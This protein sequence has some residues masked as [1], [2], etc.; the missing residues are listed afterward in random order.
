MCSKLWM[1]KT[2]T[3]QLCKLIELNEKRMSEMK[4]SFACFKASAAQLSAISSE[5]RVGKSLDFPRGMLRR[6]AR[7]FPN[8]HT[9]H[10]G[11]V[12][13][14]KGRCSTQRAGD[15]SIAVIAL[16]VPR[17]CPR[18]EAGGEARGAASAHFA[19]I[20]NWSHFNLA[21]ENPRG[22]VKYLLT[23]AT[24]NWLSLA[25]SCSRCQRAKCLF[26]VAASAQKG[27]RF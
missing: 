8:I 17:K 14:Q 22:S 27:M 4:S 15:D 25:G 11:G 26:R 2:L 7:R 1:S 21:N 6:R 5:E 12:F 23:R 24:G 3:Q 10:R 20:K 18:E 19:F 9:Q 13:F 16:L